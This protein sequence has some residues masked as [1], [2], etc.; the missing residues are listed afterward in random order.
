MRHD[1]L[2]PIVQKFWKRSK[3][4]KSVL[5]ELTENVVPHIIINVDYN[6][7][8]KEHQKNPVIDSVELY[9]VFWIEY[10]REAFFCTF[11]DEDMYLRIGIIGIQGNV[12]DSFYHRADEEGLKTRAALT[13]SRRLAFDFVLVVMGVMARHRHEGKTSVFTASRNK[14]SVFYSHG[15]VTVY[16]RIFDFKK[17]PP[18]EYTPPEPGSS[19]IRKKEHDV[20]GHYRQY[21]SGV[22][23]F[24][25]PHKRG[26][27]SLGRVTS[28]FT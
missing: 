26:D 18:A 23:V 22:K 16:K 11:S 25:R 27:P 13:Y 14:G 19:G 2:P 9:G 21:K 1:R 5:K 15:D 10:D 4:P 3:N 24:V 6:Q 28:V 17:L 12:V 8:R 20:V 7:V